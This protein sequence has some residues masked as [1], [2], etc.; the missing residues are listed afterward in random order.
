MKA[1]CF[2]LLLSLCSMGYVPPVFA[3]ASSP[4]QSIKPSF[5]QRKQCHRRCRRNADPKACRERCFL[6]YARIGTEVACCDADW[7]RCLAC[8]D[9]VS[10]ITYCAH[11]PQT[12]GCPEVA[13]QPT[14]CAE[15]TA[16]CL[17]CQKGATVTTICAEIPQLDGCAEHARMADC[18]VTCTAASQSECRTLCERA[19]STGTTSPQPNP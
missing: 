18:M 19:S 7:A 6:R 12:R 10:I 2:S 3:Q 5:K 16:E 14:C 13:A 11:R 9:K 4:L 1:L 17:S 8:K 15:N